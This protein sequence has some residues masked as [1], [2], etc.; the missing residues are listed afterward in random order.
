MS[1]TFKGR[2][3][4]LVTVVGALTLLTGCNLV[5]GNSVDKALMGTSELPR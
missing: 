3:G 2:V 4:Q 5:E 1:R